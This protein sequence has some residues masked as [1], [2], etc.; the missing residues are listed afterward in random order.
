MLKV[1][2]I[3]FNTVQS[4]NGFKEVCPY[5]FGE[6]RGVE[7]VRH[8]DNPTRIRLLHSLLYGLEQCC[9]GFWIIERHSRRINGGNTPPLEGENEPFRYRG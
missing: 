7:M 9:V 5:G 6:L 4:A 1:K 8:T 2:N 3:F